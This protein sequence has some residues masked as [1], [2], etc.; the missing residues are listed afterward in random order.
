MKRIYIPYWDWEDWINGMWSKSDNEY[1]L[2]QRAIEF[3]GDHVAYGNAMKEVL[4][5]WPNTMLNSLTNTSINRKAFLGHCAVCYKLK[6]PEYIT[7]D[8]W[9]RLTEQQRVE[10]NLQAENHIKNWVNEYE[11]K[12][13]AIH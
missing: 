6:I 5:A 11:R 4:V 9:H 3:T 7:R 10:A 12:N 1:D 13:K 8:A 2:L